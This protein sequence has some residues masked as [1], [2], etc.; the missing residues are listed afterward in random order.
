LGEGFFNG[1]WKAFDT[2]ANQSVVVKAR[3]DGKGAF[4]KGAAAREELA[5][6]CRVLQSL[7]S[8][9]REGTDDARRA[10]R[11]IQCFEGPIDTSETPFIVLEHWG[12]QSLQDF[13]IDKAVAARMA[14]LEEDD[15]DPQQPFTAKMAQHLWDQL[16]EALAYM[17]DQRH[18]CQWEHGDLHLG[19]VMVDTQ[20]GSAPM[21]KV[22]DLGEGRPLRPAAGVWSRAWAWF[23]NV[24]LRSRRQL[25]REASFGARERASRRAAYQ[26]DAWTLAKGWHEAVEK[27][28]LPL[29]EQ[30]GIRNLLV[31]LAS[32]ARTAETCPLPKEWLEPK[33]NLRLPGADVPPAA[34]SP[35]FQASAEAYCAAGPFDALA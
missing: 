17:G 30:T 6:E 29:H 19:N 11:I 13:L 5:H 8:Q 28:L 24:F 3:L 12:D 9:R 21:L 4:D 33:G 16:Q 32:C 22:I 1:A 7:H 34:K 2:Q 25:E 15:D 18:S 35:P 23:R 27:G 20:A 10:S 26:G 31:R 14:Q